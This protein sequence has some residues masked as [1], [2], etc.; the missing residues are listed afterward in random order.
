M[1]SKNA[2][3]LA[4]VSIIGA[5]NV[6]STCA[7]LLAANSVADV[8]L[9]DKFENLAQA[10]ALDIGQ[11]AVALASDSRVVAAKGAEEL[12]GSEVVVIT[13]GLARKPGMSRA[14]LTKTNAST[15][16]EISLNIKEYAPDTVVIVVSNP[17]DILTWIVLKETGFKRRQVLGMAGSTDNSRLKYFS[18]EK[19]KV[20]SNAVDSHVLGLHS[21]NMIIEKESIFIDGKP[22]GEVLNDGELDEIKT[23][24]RGGGAQIVG[25][26]GNGSAYYL[27]GAGAYLMAKAVINDTSQVFDASVYL[28]GEYGLSG[29]CLGVP[30]SIGAGGIKAIEE[31]QLS[32]R[33][34][35]ELKENAHIFNEQLKFVDSGRGGVFPPT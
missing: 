19:A 32:E 24:T 34:L 33:S 26:L 25:L 2:E 9:F 6:G 23:S 8:F 4:K 10:K 5:G 16:T 15:A 28:E 18:A 22:A 11:A 14:D 17:L 30:A 12:N 3:N 13:A 21:D 35:M 31:L 27:P 7:F 20:S 29:V 1:S